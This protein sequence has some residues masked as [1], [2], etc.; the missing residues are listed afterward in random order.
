MPSQVDQMTSLRILELN[1]NQIRG[2]P[3]QMGDLPNLRKLYLNNNKIMFVPTELG[4]L[5]KLVVLRMV[6]APT[7]NCKRARERAR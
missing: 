4:Y 3:P 5:P 7:K 6:P 2:L 1:H